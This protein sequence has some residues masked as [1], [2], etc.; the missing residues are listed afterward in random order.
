MAERPGFE[1][2][3]GFPLYT[4][5]RRA[6]SATRPPLH[7]SLGALKKCQG[8]SGMLQKDKEHKAKW[9]SLS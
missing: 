4:L 6:P 7:E 1:P 2:G 8:Q 3:I 9:T 5:S